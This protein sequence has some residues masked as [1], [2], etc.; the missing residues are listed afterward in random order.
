MRPLIIYARAVAPPAP[1]L[2]P[3]LDVTIRSSVKDIFIEVSSIFP[4]FA[5]FW[6]SLPKIQ[7]SQY[8]L[9]IWGL[10]HGRTPDWEDC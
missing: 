9:S 7:E 10:A 3:P 5:Q 2:V 8:T 4:A 1:H 6:E